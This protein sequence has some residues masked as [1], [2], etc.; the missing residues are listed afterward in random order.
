MTSTLERRASAGVDTMPATRGPSGV[1]TAR[2]AVALRLARRQL[3]RTYLSSLLVA[4]LV[5]LPIA[6]LTAYAVIGMSGVPSPQERADVELGRTKAW[7][8]ATGLPGAGFWQAPTD[9][10]WTGYPDDG[11]VP[12]GVPLDDPTHLL[13]AGTEALRTIDSDVRVTTPNGTTTM[14]VTTGETWDPRFAGRYDVIDGQTPTSTGE[15]MVTPATLD[16]LEIEIGDDIRLPD[17][18]QTLTVTGTLRA[19]PLAGDVPALFFPEATGPTSGDVRWYLPDTDLDWADVE[20]LNADGVVAFSR[21]VVLDPPS[22]D[23]DTPQGS[24]SPWSGGLWSIV[25]VLLAAGLFSAYVV[26]ML[27]GAAFAVAARRQQRS[28]AVAASVGAT[29]SDLR[30]IIVMQ[31]TLLGGIGGLLGIATGIGAAA[32][33]MALTADGSATQYWGFHV[34]WPILAA[35][36]AFAVIVG[37]LSAIVPARTVARTDALAALRGARRPQRPRVS[38]PIWGVVL[39]LIGVAVTIGASLVILA[40]DVAGLPADAPLRV[41]PPFGIVVGPIVVQLGILL[42]G[43]WLLWTASRGLSRLGLAAR[44]A[45]RDAAANSSRTVPA[46]A[47]IAATVFI[48]VF[49]LGQGAMQSGYTA[50]SWAFQAPLGSLAVSFYP[51]GTVPIDADAAERATDAGLELARASGA[52]STAVIAHQ[53]EAWSYPTAQDIPEDQI[54]AIAVLPDRYLLDPTVESSYSWNGQSPSNPFSVIPVDQLETAL[55]ADLSARQLEAYRGGAAVVTDSRYIEDESIEVGAWTSRNA[56]SGLAPDNIWSQHP[57]MP[58]RADPVWTERVDALFFDLPRQPVL[59]AISP[60]TAAAFGM[61]VQP[62]LVIAAFDDAVP[63]SERDRIQALSETT[64]SAEWTLAPFFEDGPPSDARWMVPIIVAVSVL[65]LGASAVALGLARFERRPDDATLAAVG[66]TGGLRRRIG[67]WQG[68][69]IA[70]FGTIAGAIAGVLPPI[71]FSIQSGGTWLVSDVPWLL[72]A[73]LAVALPLVIAAASWLIPPR[74]PELTRR[75][76]IA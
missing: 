5:L 26:V 19:A 50:R 22:L 65:V 54:M 17:A 68:L 46:F 76:A 9:P 74:A 13:P 43:R 62:T 28:L 14:R 70:G 52:V 58:E 61:T 71:G 67:F 21:E 23:P 60:E 24:Y 45:S 8:A 37:T 32:A 1:S 38:R 18:G 63:T 64:S 44:L 10:D 12:D 53:T 7:I 57:D 25:V 75:T 55:G 40:S 6:A 33:T 35:I 20:A 73:M 27:S 41:I 2:W 49:A 31:G 56:Y 51:T 3:R 34:P 42:S 4:A 69:L 39:M 48:A 16:R 72:L 30:R 66:G 47:A 36:L 29:P 11:Q 15:I 59:V